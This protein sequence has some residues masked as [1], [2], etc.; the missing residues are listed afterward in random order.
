MPD[1]VPKLYTHSCLILTV[2]LRVTTQASK[3][4]EI[5]QFSGSEAEVP[6]RNS[7]PRESFCYVF[8]VPCLLFSVCLPHCILIE[9]KSVSSSGALGE[10]RLRTCTLRSR[11]PRCCGCVP[12]SCQFAAGR[13]IQIPSPSLL[14]DLKFTLKVVINL[15]QFVFHFLQLVPRSVL[16]SLT[17]YSFA[18]TVYS[19]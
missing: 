3:L 17:L 18:I 19:I 5:T 12:S 8:A 10:L 11:D 16:V 9:K 14:Q 1:I 4:P 2:T 7:Q 6:T 15:Y 13:L